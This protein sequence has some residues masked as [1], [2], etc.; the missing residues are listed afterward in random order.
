[1]VDKR[2][3]VINALGDIAKALNIKLDYVVDETREYLVCDDIKIC[4]N[5]TSVCGI[6]EELFGYVFLREWKYRYLGAFDKQT[7]NH[8]KQYWFDAN[9]NQPFCKH[10]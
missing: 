3:Q 10:N 4:T 2:E 8:I 7:R 5:D 6:R 9:M 1:M